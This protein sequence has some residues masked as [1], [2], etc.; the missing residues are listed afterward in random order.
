M[1][2]AVLILAILGAAGSG[3]LGVRWMTDSLTNK[4]QIEADR[5]QAEK[6]RPLLNLMGEADPK[7]KAQLADYDA[8][9]HNAIQA[10]KAYPFL[11]AGVGLGVWGGLLGLARRGKSGAA[12]L[13]VA[14]LGP[15]VLLPKT[16]IFT[17]C[18]ILA[19]L[20]CLLVRP[21]RRARAGLVAEGI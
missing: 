15:A 11:L 4:D 3:F 9:Y 5:A 18:L 2:I 14:A 8:K 10:M 17:F 6:L 13:L 19:G 1:R 21:R 20:L 12:L 7:M 16:L